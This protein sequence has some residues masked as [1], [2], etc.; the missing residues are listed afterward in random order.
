M[1]IIGDL[2]KYICQDEDVKVNIGVG[3]F[4]FFSF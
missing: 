1:L 4:R 2:L 3:D